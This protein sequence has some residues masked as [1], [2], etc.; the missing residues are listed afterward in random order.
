MNKHHRHPLAFYGIILSALHFTALL[1]SK[2]IPTLML[3]P[4]DMIGSGG[5]KPYWP[6]SRL[7]EAIQSGGDI[8]SMP[9]RQVYEAWVGMPDA[10]A[11]MLFIANSCLWGFALALLFRIV[12]GCLRVSH[13]PSPA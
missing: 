2:L 13:E 11:L 12:L 9:A 5:Q 7:R 10:A 6:P 8:L 4:E 1:C 3:R